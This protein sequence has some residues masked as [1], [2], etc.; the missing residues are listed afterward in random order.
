MLNDTI[1]RRKF[2]KDLALA[3]GALVASGGAA[4]A[5]WTQASAPT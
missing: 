1:T 4:G 2:V 5:S 3:T